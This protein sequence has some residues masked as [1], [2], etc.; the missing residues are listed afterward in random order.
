MMGF[1]FRKSLRFGPLRFNLSKR[2]VGASIG[3]EG[4]RVGVDAGGHEYVAGGRHGFYFRERGSRVGAGFL[5][6]VVLG[7]IAMLAL[8]MFAGC[9]SMS[10]ANR[11][12][13][14]AAPIPTPE[15]PAPDVPRPDL[16]RGQAAPGT[17]S[18]TR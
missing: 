5:V 13:P 8:M 2:G 17:V 15:A 4:K 3:V 7:V 10:R 14:A 18:G 16:D 11:V 6:A 12:S 9:S 1:Y